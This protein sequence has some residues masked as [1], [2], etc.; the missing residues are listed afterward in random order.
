MR[1]KKIF[2]DFLFTKDLLV[3]SSRCLSKDTLKNSN[4]TKRDETSTDIIRTTCTFIFP[5]IMGCLETNF[6]NLMSSSVTTETLYVLVTSLTLF[7]LVVYMYTS[8]LSF[9]MFLL[10]L[11][12]PMHFKFK[13]F[14]NKKNQSNIDVLPTLT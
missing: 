5:N 1:Q 14:I 6:L 9:I 12:D 13:V 10:C 3:N 11:Y 4:F 7:Y 8:S 2:K